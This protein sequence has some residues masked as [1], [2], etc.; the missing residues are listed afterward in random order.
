MPSKRAHSDEGKRATY[1]APFHVHNTD[2]KT[3]LEM[4]RRAELE[5]AQMSLLDRG[6]RQDDDSLKI[7]Y[8]GNIELARKPCIAV[9]GTRNVTDLGRK[10]ANRFARE[11]VEAGIVV[12]SGLAAGVDAQAL[13]GA[14]QNGGSVIA[15]IGTPLDKAYPAANANLQE[16]IYRDHLLISQFAIGERTY[17][18][19]FPARNRTM[20]AISDGSVIIEASESSGTLHQAAECVRLNRWLGI[21]KGVVEDKRLSWPSKFLDYKRCLVLE[22]TEEFVEKVYGR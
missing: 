20:A 5:P 17:P 4:G 12:V 1:Q 16:R 15:V 6:K 11:L 3:I 7:F 2:L 13:G 21:S 19:S 18:S 10:R 14:M 22:S 8:A 9:I